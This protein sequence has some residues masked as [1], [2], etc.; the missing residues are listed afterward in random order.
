MCGACHAGSGRLD[1][2]SLLLAIVSHR[3]LAPPGTLHEHWQRRS[4]DEGLGRDE[5]TLVLVMSDHAHTY[6]RLFLDPREL[7]RHLRGTLEHREDLS[8]GIDEQVLHDYAL[9]ARHRGKRNR[10]EP[11]RCRHLGNRPVSEGRQPSGGAEAAAET[12]LEAAVREA[13]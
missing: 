3:R 4:S 8:F 9:L 10:R 2:S 5:I 11:S 7:P 13:A 12:E 1:F 6:L